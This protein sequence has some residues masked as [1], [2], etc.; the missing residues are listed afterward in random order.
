MRLGL[1]DILNR[2][3]SEREKDRSEF[4]VAHLE[5]E[6][7]QRSLREKLVKARQDICRCCGK[8][9]KLQTGGESQNREHKYLLEM[10]ERKCFLHRK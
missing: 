8:I 9:S 1:F 4:A 2:L 5:N 10:L 3:L 7:A 6:Q